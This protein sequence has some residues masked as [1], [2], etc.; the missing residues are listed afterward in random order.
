MQH[1]PQHPTQHSSS[2]QMRL[3]ARAWLSRRQQQQVHRTQRAKPRCRSLPQNL[4]PAVVAVSPL[5]LPQ[6][7]ARK[8]LSQ[9]LL[10]R[11]RAGLPLA[12]HRCSHTRCHRRSQKLPLR[13]WTRLQSR[14]RR[15]S[16]PR[17]LQ[18]GCHPRH[19]WGPHH[20]P[21][22]SARRRRP[23]QALQIRL[24]SPLPAAHGLPCKRH[25]GA[26]QQ[27]LA[28]M[29]LLVLQQCQV[30][31]CHCQQDHLRRHTAMHCPLQLWSPECG[32]RHKD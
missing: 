13:L 18:A 19:Q 2:L 4:P 29:Q 11:R 1:P 10:S 23:C 16:R 5:R 15:Q 7:T 17:S 21:A 14:Q 22:P 25:Q 12:V 28:P 30:L 3:Q 24:S 6:E 8:Q 27:V 9:K 31:L 32:S 26:G 20:H